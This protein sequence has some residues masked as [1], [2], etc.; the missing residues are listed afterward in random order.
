MRFRIL[1]AEFEAAASYKMNKADWLEGT[2][3]GRP[4]WKRT[5]KN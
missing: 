5:R 3:E 1:D 4:N 2:W